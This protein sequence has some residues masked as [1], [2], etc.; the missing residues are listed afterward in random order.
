VDISAN[1]LVNKLTV[2]GETLGIVFPNVS[3]AKFGLR[4]MM[5]NKK[6]T[7]KKL[8]VSTKESNLSV[9]GSYDFSKAHPKIVANIKSDNLDLYDVFPDMREESKSK[10]VHPNRDLNVFKD[11]P[12]FG[13]M[14]SM[15]DAKL[16]VDM[17]ELRIYRK[18]YAGNILIKANLENSTGTVV[19]DLDFANGHIRTKLQAHHIDSGLLKI[20]AAGIGR[21][22][23]VGDILAAVDEFDVISDLPT[24]FD[25]Y[26]VGH[27]HDLS[28]LIKNTNGPI[29]VTNSSGGYA[30]KDLMDVL[31]GK[32]F[33]T[34]LREDVRGIFQ[35][36]KKNERMKILCAVAN[37]K[38]RQ[39]KIELD[40]NVAV[41]TRAVNIRG[42][43][44]V[45]FG[46]EKMELA[47]NTI[48]VD[49]IKLSISGNVVNSMEFVGNLAE[50]DLKWKKEEVAEKLAT[51][52]GVGLAV[53]ALT[54]G[55]GL[56]V[57]AG[58]GLV[59]G[60][61]FGNWTADKTPCRT[62]LKDGAPHGKRGDPVFMNQPVD[63]MAESFIN[64]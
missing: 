24:D 19:T 5:E 15:F 56:L 26:L 51:A 17:K 37:M 58:V 35:G 30:H 46:K 41:Q 7:I 50:P 22:I 61:V 10:W 16:D 21:G 64:E 14:L 34:S 38:V 47:L 11:V 59:G 25:F 12:L 42:V 6:I 39:G 27:G 44:N 40:R 45:N 2:L 1:G 23:V 8:N 33:I 48:P 13:A 53:G 29:R 43:G 36:K 31:Y 28:E 55:V 4:A 49:G 32:D 57:G 20:R 63:K 3:S 52:T 54:G 9:T 60:D 62:A 18:L